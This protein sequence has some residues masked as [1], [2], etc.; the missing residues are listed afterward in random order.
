[1][2]LG[3]C[4]PGRQTKRFH[5]SSWLRLTV[6]GRWPPWSAVGVRWQERTKLSC[7][8]KQTRCLL[9]SKLTSESRKR[10]TYIW[11]G[12]STSQNYPRGEHNEPGQKT[13]WRAVPDYVYNVTG[14]YFR[15]TKR[16]SIPLVSA[17]RSNRGLAEKTHSRGLV[18]NVS[19][20]TDMFQNQPPAQFHWQ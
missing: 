16:S 7:S 17:R 11:R 19:V 1:M 2:L 10:L 12:C 14:Y 5:T 20:E 9:S 15:N 3:K 13:R 8:R 4:Q 18:W 6:Q